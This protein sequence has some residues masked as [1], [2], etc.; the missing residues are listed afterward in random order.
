MKR[1]T[2]QAWERRVAALFGCRRSADSGAGG[3]GTKSDTTHPNLY[4]EIKTKASHALVTLWDETA[5]QAR[6]E[7]KTPVVA[8]CR[9]GEPTGRVWLLVADDHLE[10]LAREYVGRDR[11]KVGGVIGE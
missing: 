11:Q 1:S 5:D 7:G 2:W 9:A 10:E 3:T 6:R 4:I 8:L